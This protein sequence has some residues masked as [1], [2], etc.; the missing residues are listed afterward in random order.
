MEELLERDGTSGFDKKEGTGGL[1]YRSGLGLGLALAENEGTKGLGLGL[2]LGL[3]KNEG[4]GG[5]ERA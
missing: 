1:E 5:L 2:G 3:D 4:T